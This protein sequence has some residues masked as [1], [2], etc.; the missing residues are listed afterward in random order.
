MFFQLFD[1]GWFGEVKCWEDVELREWWVC[2]GMI[3]MEVDGWMSV[4]CSDVM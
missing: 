3:G 2:K 4:G 1:G